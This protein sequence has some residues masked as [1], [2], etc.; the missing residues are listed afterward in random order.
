MHL[1]LLTTA[2]VCLIGVSAASAADKTVHD[3]DDGFSLTYPEEWTNEAPPGN[4]IKL[5]VKSGEKGLVCRVSAGLNDPLDPNMP[6]DPKTYI[7]KDWSMDSWQKM[8]GA[9]FGTAQ[10][11]KDRSARFPDGYPVRIAEMDFHYSDS[12]VDFYGH[13]EV[14][15]SLRGTRYGLA[16][17]GVAG[18]SAEEAEQR[19]APLA[20]EAGKVVSSFVLDAD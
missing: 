9:A 10:F 7:E 6:R 12:D 18:D 1:F 14:A 19:W 2:T 17:C 4:S 15:I 8:V 3:T 16:N 20:A 13:A 11:S 5:K